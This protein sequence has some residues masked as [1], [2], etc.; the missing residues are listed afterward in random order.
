MPAFVVPVLV[1]FLG[2]STQPSAD[3]ASLRRIRAALAKP[4]P[5]LVV[6]PPAPQPTFKVTIQQHPYF[7][8]RP[9]VWTFAGGG[10]PTTQRPTGP[11]QPLITVGVPI[12]GGGEGGVLPMLRA[13]KSALQEHAARDEVERAMAEFCAAHSCNE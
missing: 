10:T 11:G 6:R 4:A 8:E 9:F 13:A 12:G 2:Q 7:V 1:L 5:T 3:D